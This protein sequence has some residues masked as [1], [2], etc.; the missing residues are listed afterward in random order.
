MNE[1]RK[2]T[3]FLAVLGFISL[4]LIFL[5]G[6]AL[7]IS[8]FFSTWF[9]NETYSFI[10]P[11][12]GGVYIILA[13]LVFFPTLYL[14]RFSRNARQA[15]VTINESENAGGHMAKAIN[16]LKMY[17][18]FTGFLIIFLLITYVIAII[19]FVIAY[20]MRPVA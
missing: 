19:G 16:Y 5:A 18:R 10:S 8:S 3:H 6:I 12:I 20:M 14:Q 1:I 11:W 13:V 7:V 9:Q 2:W 15:L 17:Y 4:A